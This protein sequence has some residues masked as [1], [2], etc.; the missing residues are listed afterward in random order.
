MFI[1]QTDINLPFLTMDAG[2]PK[3]L[4]LTLSRAKFE[5][6][7]GDLIQRTF[8]PCENAIRDAGVQRSDVHDVL[9]VG[10]MTRMP[11]VHCMYIHVHCY[12]YRY[13][14]M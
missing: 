13:W 4:S 11:K 2:G 7:T 10:G 12:M 3:H 1:L 6:I 9:L 14:G 8:N 5:S